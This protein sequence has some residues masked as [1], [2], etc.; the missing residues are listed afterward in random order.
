MRGIGSLK[1]QRKC[2]RKGI[3]YLTENESGELL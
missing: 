3:I 1:L 2:I